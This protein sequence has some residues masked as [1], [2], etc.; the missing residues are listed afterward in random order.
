MNHQIRCHELNFNETT[1]TTPT[2][3]QTQI[4]FDELVNFSRLPNASR[5]RCLLH[6]QTMQITIF[7]AMKHQFN[8]LMVNGL[9]F[10]ATLGPLLCNR[11]IAK[12]KG[13]LNTAIGGCPPPNSTE[14]D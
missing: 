4:Q 5:F 9:L 2:N 13:E 10:S 12:C 1:S 14:C 11:E 7:R 8:A 6:R 3:C